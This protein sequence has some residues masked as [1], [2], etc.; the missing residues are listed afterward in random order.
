MIQEYLNQAYNIRLRFPNI[1]GVRLTNPK[2]DRQ[3]ILP[4]EVCTVKEGQFYKQRIPD[5]LTADVVKFA[6]LRPPDRFAAIT[7][8][9]TDSTNSP[10]CRLH[11]SF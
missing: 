1:V 5:H 11:V 6:T 3:I 4:L 9:S 7:G 8:A 10:V 2:A